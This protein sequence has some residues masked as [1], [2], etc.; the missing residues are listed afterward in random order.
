MPINKIDQSSD[1]WTKGSALIAGQLIWKQ[2][3]QVYVDKEYLLQARSTQ[4]IHYIKGHKYIYAI[5]RK[6]N[7]CRFT[8]SKNLCEIYIQT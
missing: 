5:Q 8:K 4:S 2:I 6:L 1:R 7:T 3:S